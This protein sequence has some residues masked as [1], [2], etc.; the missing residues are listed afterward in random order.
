MESAIGIMIMGCIALVPGLN[1]LA[2]FFSVIFG[3][4]L[5]ISCVRPSKTKGTKSVDESNNSLENPFRDQSKKTTVKPGTRKSA[6]KPATTKNRKPSSTK[7][8]SS[9]HK[10]SR[11]K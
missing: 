9:A 4:G 5:M 8:T 10:P 6:I 2:S 1:T 7:P 3:T 11:K